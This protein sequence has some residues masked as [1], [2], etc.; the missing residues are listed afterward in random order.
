MTLL[1][2]VIMSESCPR[3]GLVFETVRTALETDSVRVGLAHHLA[4]CPPIVTREGQERLVDAIC[5]YKQSG[6]EVKGGGVKCGEADVA[7]KPSRSMAYRR[8]DI[9]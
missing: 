7:H 4:K 9:N 1:G 2:W 8:P 3:C 6:K 5:G